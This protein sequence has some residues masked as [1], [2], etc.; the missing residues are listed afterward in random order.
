MRIILIAAIQILL[1]LTVFSQE[2]KS[3]VVRAGEIPAEVLPAE[4]LYIFPV[5]KTGIVQ[6]RDGTTSTQKLNYNII[7]N[8][9][10]FIG[11]KG[12]TLTIAYPATIKNILIDTS[13]FLYDKDYL[14]VIN[15]VN[16][17]KIALKQILIQTPY[18]TRGGYDAA[19]GASSITTFSTI[20]S[21]GAIANLL[22]KK[23]VSLQKE[24]SYFVSDE[25]NHFFKA[26]KKA[27][28]NIFKNKKSIIEKFLNENSI[29]YSKQPDLEKLLKFC[30]SVHAS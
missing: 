30:D 28:L 29:N 20:S 1:S 13:L 7:L 5:F 24:S 12:D 17:F 27:F 4:A 8:E 16:S 14:Q 9:M 6:M 15:Q 19:S 25:F 23:D 3:Y 11:P 21:H 10:Q 26:D 18:R 2:K 22:V